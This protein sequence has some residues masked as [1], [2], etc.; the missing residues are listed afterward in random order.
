[1]DK[2]IA[3]LGIPN[4]Y[5][6][7]MNQA[8]AKMFNA[9][10]LTPQRYYMLKLCTPQHR[11]TKEYFLQPYKWGEAEKEIE[12]FLSLKD[13]K[14]NMFCSDQFIMLAEPPEKYAQHFKKAKFRNL[15]I[16][17]SKSPL[18]KA[19]REFCKRHGLR[20]IDHDY[21]L[22]ELGLKGVECSIEPIEVKLTGIF[23]VKTR[24]VLTDK[25]FKKKYSEFLMEIDTTR[26]NELK[27]TFGP[28]KEGGEDIVNAG[29]R[30]ACTTKDE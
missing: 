13:V 30:E 24:E 26:Y 23:I 4:V 3:G 20:T 14:N 27:E 7:E 2:K 19:W 16:S 28:K 12:A 10:Y 29:E 5:A 6:S 15:Y 22:N 9:P 17:M 25:P 18:T 21:W 8:L 11:L 1:M